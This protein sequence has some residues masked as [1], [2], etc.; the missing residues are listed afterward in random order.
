MIST[1]RVALWATSASLSFA[2]FRK[3]FQGREPDGLQSFGRFVPLDGFRMSQLLDEFGDGGG[4]S[5]RSGLLVFH[6]LF[7]RGLL[8]A[9]RPR[10]KDR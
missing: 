9:G 8:G 2:A 4:I 7:R 1:R 5:F 3:R 6:V 10:E